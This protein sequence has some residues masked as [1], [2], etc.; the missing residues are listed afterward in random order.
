MGSVAS[1]LF[2]FLTPHEYHVF[3]EVGHSIPV[4]G[5]VKASSVDTHRNIGYR[6]IAVGVC[7][8]RRVF[9]LNKQNFE[10]VIQSE[11]VVHVFVAWRLDHLSFLL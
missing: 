7:A 2:V 1:L 5:V 11:S 10:L 6:V 9:V 8:G 3:E 4:L